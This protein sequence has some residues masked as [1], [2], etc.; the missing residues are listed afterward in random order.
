M[1]NKKIAVIGGGISGITASYLLQKEYAVSLFEKNEYIGGHT[2][3]VIVPDGDDAGTPVDTGFIVFNNRTY[4]N[5]LKF[6]KELGVKYGNTDMSFSYTSDEENVSYNTNGLPGIFAQRHKIFSKRQWRFFNGLVKYGKGMEEAFHS[7]KLKGLSLKEYFDSTD[8]PEEVVNWLVVPMAA[9]IWSSSFSDILDYPAETFARFYNNH[10][11][12]TLFNHPQWY[13]VEGGSRS[14]VEKFLMNFTGT[15]HK[16]KPVSTIKRKNKKITIICKDGYNEDFDAVVIATHADEALELLHK[17][18]DAEKK[19]LGAWSYS[20]N[21]TI[22]HTDTSFLPKMRR[23]W[24]SWNYINRPDESNN[25]VAVTYWMNLLQN[26]DTKKTYCVTLNPDREVD[27]DKVIA[28]FEYKHPIFNFESL[29]SQD[30]LNTLNGE[31][32]T[33]FCGAYF[34][35]GFHEDGCLSGV[36][37]AK[38]L[39]VDF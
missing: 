17:P 23:V 3:T 18:T 32:N 2:N 37:V 34:R 27:P 14:Y 15:V 29:D 1:K 28:E 38:L 10:G 33:Y 30:K 12:L 36:N 31:K 25:P 13:Y 35:Y 6:F 22:L 39:G 11:L 5:L 9:A 7:G 26:L 16:H 4:P 19:L 24:A 8:L 21:R 20:T